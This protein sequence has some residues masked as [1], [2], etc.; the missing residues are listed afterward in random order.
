[1]ADAGYVFDECDAVYDYWAV[2][3]CLV[4]HKEVGAA[5]ELE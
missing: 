2:F 1:M 4:C 5:G 3:A